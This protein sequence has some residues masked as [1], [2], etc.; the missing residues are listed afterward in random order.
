MVATVPP[1]MV[2]GM[3]RP[4]QLLPMGRQYVHLSIDIDTAIQ[5]GRRK[6]NKPVLLQIETDGAM[7]NGTVF[8]RGNDIVWLANHISSEFIA[9]HVQE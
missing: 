9:S 3:I 2:S 8:Y 5:V 1:K 4:L 6:S 7:K